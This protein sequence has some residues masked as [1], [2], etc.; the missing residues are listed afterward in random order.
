MFF[1]FR[2]ERRITWAVLIWRVFPVLLL[3]LVLLFRV[4]YEY[5]ELED[6]GS[7]NYEEFVILFGLL[8]HKN[9]LVLLL[10]LF[11]NAE[12]PFFI[13]FSWEIGEGL[14]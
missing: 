8:N 1:F 9:C 12:K 2:Y 14:F 10:V 6:L 11:L 3:V 13:F 5:F 4:P 7:L